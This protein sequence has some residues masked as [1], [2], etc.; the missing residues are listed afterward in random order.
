MKIKTDKRILIASAIDEINTTFKL[1][2][3][4]LKYYLI[5]L[6]NAIHKVKENLH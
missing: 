3:M 4:T 1:L 2:N 5:A 6:K